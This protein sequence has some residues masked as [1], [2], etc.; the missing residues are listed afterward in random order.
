MSPDK[1]FRNITFIVWK[2]F[3]GNGIS[4]RFSINVKVWLPLSLVTSVSTLA[5]WSRTTH[6]CPVCMQRGMFFVTIMY[7]TLAARCG[8]STETGSTE[9]LPS[10][11]MEKWAQTIVEGKK[12]VRGWKSFNDRSFID[13]HVNM[14]ICPCVRE[15]CYVFTVCNCRLHIFMTPPRTIKFTSLYLIY[16]VK[17]L[18]C[19][20]LTALNEK[21]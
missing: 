3:R 5:V 19:H 9:W 17:H 4:N 13:S 11:V 2:N 18:C 20:L 6:P 1:N 8:C 12:Q 10:A 15:H 21:S 16:T 14:C 7:T